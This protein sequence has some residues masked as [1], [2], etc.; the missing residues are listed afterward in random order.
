MKINEGW[1]G[2]K[3]KRL[4]TIHIQT[5]THT[6]GYMH[7]I[8]LDEARWLVD[9]KGGLYLEGGGA[10]LTTVLRAAVRLLAR[11]LCVCVC[12]CKYRILRASIIIQLKTRIGS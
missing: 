4:T 3:R 2:E 8:G 1:E 7:D 6:Y 9:G 5:D 12:V 11:L 10:N